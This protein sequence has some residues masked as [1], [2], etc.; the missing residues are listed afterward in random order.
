MLNII[1]I[2]IWAHF[3]NILKMPKEHKRQ[4]KIIKCLF[5]LPFPVFL[6]K[7]TEC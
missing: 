2:I 5:T 3:G 7:G 1:I 4:S 6:S